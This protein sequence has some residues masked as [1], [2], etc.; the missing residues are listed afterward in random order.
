[1]E[2]MTNTNTNTTTE[3]SNTFPTTPYFIDADDI[4]LDD[5]YMI[6]YEEWL[7]KNGFAN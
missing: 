4:D 6:G 1:M 3:Y 5:V 7:K 2:N